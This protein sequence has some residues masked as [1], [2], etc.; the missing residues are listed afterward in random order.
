MTAKGSL[1]SAPVSAVVRDMIT[2]TNGRNFKIALRHDAAAFTAAFILARC[3]Q[4]S[5]QHVCAFGTSIYPN[6][7]TEGGERRDHKIVQVPRSA[8]RKKVQTNFGSL[9]RL[10]QQHQKQP[11]DA[12][13]ATSGHRRK[14]GLAT[15]CISSSRQKNL[16]HHRTGVGPLITAVRMSC[17]CI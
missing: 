8:A 2:S 15:R 5:V 4:S 12:C 16:Q 1:S 13:K 17:R 9:I 7:M 3:M 11:E 10:Q 14:T 6:D